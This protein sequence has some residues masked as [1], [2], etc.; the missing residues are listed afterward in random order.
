MIESYKVFI[1][2]FLDLNNLTTKVII[3]FFH[4]MSSNSIN[5]TF[6]YMLYIKYCFLI[7][8]ILCNLICSM[9]FHF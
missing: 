9:I 4:G 6:L 2:K 5:S 3:L 1:I 8:H 7:L